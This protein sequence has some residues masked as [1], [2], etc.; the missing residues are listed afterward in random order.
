MNPPHFLIIE[1][2]TNWSITNHSSSVNH[3]F[4]WRISV[5]DSWH[6][7][8]LWAPCL[9]INVL[10]KLALPEWVMCVFHLNSIWFWQKQT[11]S[12]E[13]LN[14]I[15]FASFCCKSLSSATN[16]GWSRTLHF[17]V[18][19]HDF[20][21]SFSMGDYVRTHFNAYLLL[22]TTCKNL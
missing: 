9:Y 5:S 10:E 7:I 15:I 16:V 11:A 22:Q 18:V 1:T 20:N 8:N 14:E 4:N 17:S 19:N 12:W 13:Q 3:D 6:R 21:W 2:D